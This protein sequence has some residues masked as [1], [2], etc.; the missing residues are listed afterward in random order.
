MAGNGDG[1]SVGMGDSGTALLGYLRARNYKK[2]EQALLRESLVERLHASGS[3]ASAGVA[4]DGVVDASGLGVAAGGAP[5]PVAASGTAAGGQVANVA[6]TWT[7]EPQGT[8]E[9]LRNVILLMHQKNANAAAEL[10]PLVI[11][12]GYFA[13]QNG[14]TARWICSRTSCTLCCIQWSCIAFW[15]LFVA[16]TSRKGRR[17]WSEPVR[18][19][20]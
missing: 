8:D 15:S 2:A 19:S 12:H 4:T 17:F 14:S 3:H 11:E 5:V 13:L 18:S 7:P 6:V 10:D 20:S 1:G 9:E 16:A